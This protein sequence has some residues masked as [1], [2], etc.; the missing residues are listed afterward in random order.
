MVPEGTLVLSSPCVQHT[1]QLLQTS[2]V[3]I[4]VAIILP[5]SLSRQSPLHLCPFVQQQKLLFS[6]LLLFS[7]LK[8]TSPQPQHVHL[9]SSDSPKMKRQIYP[10]SSFRITCRLSNMIWPPSPLKAHC[11]P[12]V[13]N[14]CHD[15]TLFSLLPASVCSLLLASLSFK[16]QFCRE[17]HPLGVFPDPFPRNQRVTP[18]LAPKPQLYTPI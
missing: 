16:T 5:H 12:D 3:D 10:R 6:L 8:S 17:P 14:Y 11:E 9:G 4:R 15:L 2:F 13:L 1:Y 18:F 7:P